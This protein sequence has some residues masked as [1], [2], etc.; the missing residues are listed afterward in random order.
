MVIVPS[1]ATQLAGVLSEAVME[2]AQ[3]FST[4]TVMGSLNTLQPTWLV[5]LKV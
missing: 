3:Q 4:F 1:S 2:R 5:A